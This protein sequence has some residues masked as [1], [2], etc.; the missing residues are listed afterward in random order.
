MERAATTPH[1]IGIG[2][3]AR[4]A[5]LVREL[6]DQLGFTTP[7]RK[8][9]VYLRT[10]DLE[11]VDPE[12]VAFQAVRLRSV[13]AK[14]ALLAEE[15]GVISDAEFAK[16]LGVQSRSTIKNYREQN[17][18]MAVNRGAR[19]LRYP[20]WQ[21]HK[22][23]LLPG[24]GETLSVLAAQK[25]D[26]ISTLIFFLTPAD[27]LSEKRPLDLL[28]DNEVEEVVAHARHYGDRR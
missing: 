26:P 10:M 18:I 19:N 9:D 17:K 14:E 16:R 27:A 13:N 4:A 23:E 15:G 5:L 12:E 24:L 20:A 3:P 1:E 22:H 6:M 21:I 28:R 8:V 25:I 2:D 11:K 7:E